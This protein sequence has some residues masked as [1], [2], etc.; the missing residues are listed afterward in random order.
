VYN[1]DITVNKFSSY[2]IERSH[3]SIIETIV[4]NELISIGNLDKY[5]LSTG[6]IIHVTKTSGVYPN[7]K[8]QNN[9]EY[10][11]IEIDS[12]KIGLSYQGAFFN[13][14][15]SLDIHVND[16]LRKPR[17]SKKNV[18]YNFKWD[19]DYENYTKNIFFYDLSGEQLKYPK[20]YNYDN[21]LK[22][23]GTTPLYNSGVCWD[24]SYLNKNANK[25]S[26]KIDDP[27]Y[28]KTVFDNI[29]FSLET[30]SSSNINYIP[31]PLQLFLGYNSKNEGVDN[32]ILLLEKIEDVKFSGYTYTNYG[33]N[34]T[35]T[36]ITSISEFNMSNGYI[37]YLTNEINFDFVNLGFEIGQLIKLSFSDQSP[38]NEIIFE[39]Y[40]LYKII[41]VG[42]NHIKVDINNLNSDFV[43]FST[44]AST[45]GF[46]F[47]IDVQPKIILECSVYGE[48]EI[49]DERFEINLRNLGIDIDKTIESIFYESDVKEEGI[50]Y[51]LLNDKRKEMLSNYKEIY[52]YIG[53]Y[54]A[55]INAINFFGYD[56]LELYEYYRNIN[57]NSPMYLKL[58]KI[59]IPDIFDQSIEGWSEQNYI[60]EHS[61]RKD[62]KKTNLFN[63][64]Y[65]ITDEN[66]NYVYMYKLEEVQLKLT[67]MKHWLINKGIIPISSNILDLTGIAEVNSSMYIYHDTSNLVKKSYV[68]RTGT[69]VNF[70][71]QQTLNF[72]DNYLIT[73][74]FYTNNNI[75]PNGWDCKIQTFS[76]S[77]GTSNILVPQQYLNFYK[78]DLSSINFN[79]DFKLD[80]YIYIE[81]IYYN[82]DGIGIMQNKMFDA[83]STKNYLLINN[84]FTMPKKSEKKYI[85]TDDIGWYFFNKD[86]YITLFN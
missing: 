7:I 25:S 5:N 10:N 42:K 32:N 84:N 73:V 24:I 36:A 76:L 23:I 71:Y 74:D 59:R 16:F 51:K 75:I 79:V 26:K 47:S 83:S 3:E 22:Y 9:G 45:Y 11:I 77:A 21:S 82:G 50:D 81:T 15:T 43:D 13:D 41:E 35:T 28:Q 2:K 38:T 29:L 44:S 57:K 33:Y 68:E 65:R 61:K 37:E 55:I 6:M 56:D 40:E 39:N 20:N 4:G 48:T 14:A 53:S 66:G 78:T 80:P 46:K 54:K 18:Y 19:E 30:S 67:K 64:V 62:Y 63:L 85:T 60:Q 58:S 31:E 27:K 34:A 8:A 69:A 12:N 1:L 52:D 49:E 17:Y 70:N 72:G 86:G